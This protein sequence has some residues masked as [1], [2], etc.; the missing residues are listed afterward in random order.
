MRTIECNHCGKV[1][2]FDP[3]DPSPSTL[4]KAAIGAV[5]G[6][7]IGS[8]IPYVGTAMGAYAGS[9]GVKEMCGNDVQ[10]PRCGRSI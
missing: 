8:V 9:R 6:A 5:V 4:K 3:D 10:C 7:A 2:S 1:F